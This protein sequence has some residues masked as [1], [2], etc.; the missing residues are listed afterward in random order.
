MPIIQKNVILLGGAGGKAGQKKQVEDARGRPLR[1]NKGKKELVDFLVH[2]SERSAREGVEKGG[3]TRRRLFPVGLFQPPETT[4]SRGR[5]ARRKL[6]GGQRDK[7]RRNLPKN[8]CTRGAGGSLIPEKG[9]GDRK[10][11]AQPEKRTPLG[12]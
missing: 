6:Q 4:K 10:R 1:S 12:D 8:G 11:R 3:V 5:Q 2:G 7:R 9:L